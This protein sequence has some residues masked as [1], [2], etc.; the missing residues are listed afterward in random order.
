MALNVAGCA[1]SARRPHI[2]PLAPEHFVRYLNAPF[3]LAGTLGF[4]DPGGAWDE[5]TASRPGGVCAN[6]L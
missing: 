6:R 2:V 4:A 5:D 1:L 3:R